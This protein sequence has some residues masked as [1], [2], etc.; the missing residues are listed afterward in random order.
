MTLYLEVE[1]L[2]GSGVRETI[3]DAKFLASKLDLMVVFDFNGVPMHVRSSTDVDK[4]VDRYRR[5]CRVAKKPRKDQ[6]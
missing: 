5:L 4:E 1:V 6:G 2:A 3:A